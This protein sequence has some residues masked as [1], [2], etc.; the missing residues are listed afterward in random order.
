[1]KLDDKN[2][3]N[4]LENSITASDSWILCQVGVKIHILKK[5]TYEITSTTL[6]KLFVVLDIIHS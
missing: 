5:I 6:L 3:V 4:D 2:S 1:M